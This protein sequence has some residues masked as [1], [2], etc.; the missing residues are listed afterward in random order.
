MTRLFC[1]SKYGHVKRLLPT[2]VFFIMLCSCKKEGKEVDLLSFTYKGQTYA[3][4]SS[5]YFTYKYS[6][7]PVIDRMILTRKDLFG[8]NI[9]FLF[10]SHCAYLAPENMLI[11]NDDTWGCTLVSAGGPLDSIHVFWS[12]KLLINYSEE[13]CSWRTVQTLGGKIKYEHCTITGSFEVILKNKNDSLI[14]VTGSFSKP[15]DK[16]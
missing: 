1:F 2:V 8:E 10:D 9:I 15:F 5:G 3:D 6:P 13:N 16:R 11:H 7:K 12:D 4:P 14:Q